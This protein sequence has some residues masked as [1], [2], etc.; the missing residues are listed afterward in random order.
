[1]EEG[2]STEAHSGT[3][4]CRDLK[5]LRCPTR[6][7]AGVRSREPEDCEIPAEQQRKTHESLFQD[8]AEIVVLR[9]TEDEHFGRNLTHVSVVTAVVRQSVE[10]TSEKEV[11]L[12]IGGK[13]IRRVEEVGTVVNG[14]LALDSKAVDARVGEISLEC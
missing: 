14:R 5:P 3:H 13:R 2:R 12:R 7:A 1:M 8:G 6:Q 9:S 10:P 11:T 4:K